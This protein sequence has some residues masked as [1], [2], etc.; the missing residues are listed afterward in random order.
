MLLLP[1]SKHGYFE[2][3]QGAQFKI[4]KLR[5]IRMNFTST[6]KML[7]AEKLLLA[8]NVSSTIYMPITAKNTQHKRAKLFFACCGEKKTRKPKNV[9]QNIFFRLRLLRR[10]T[11]QAHYVLLSPSP[12]KKTVRRFETVVRP[13]KKSRAPKPSTPPRVVRY[14]Q[15]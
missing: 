1:S 6:K 9:S 3:K 5:P 15:F 12:R 13:K 11:G 7:G 8:G 14:T 10:R 4:T 2:K